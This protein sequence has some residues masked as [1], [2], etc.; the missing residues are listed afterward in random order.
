MLKRSK[1]INII[2]SLIIG[3]IFAMILLLMSML[4]S[5]SFSIHKTKLVV[6]SDSNSKLYNGYALTD[7]GWDMEGELKAGHRAKAVFRGSRTE[8]GESENIMHLVITDEMGMDVTSDYDI[9]YQFGTL[10]VEPRRLLVVGESGGVT[11]G[12]LDSGSYQISPDCDQLLSGHNVQISFKNGIAD[13]TV[14]NVF[15]A[16]FTKNYFITLQL[17]GNTFFPQGSTT[18]QV[19]LF[20]I[21]SDITDTVYLKIN[22]YGD[23]LGQEKWAT[24]PVYDQLIADKYSASYLTSLLL[25][26]QKNNNPVAVQIESLCGYYAL[27][28]YMLDGD[29]QI[30][31]NDSVNRGDA[32]SVYSVNYYRYPDNL[33]NVSSVFADYER[34][35]R[36]FVYQNYLNLDETSLE[37]MR[38]LIKKQGFSASDPDIIQ[39]VAKFIQNAAVYNLDYPKSLETEPNV[40]IAFLENYKEGVCRHY[41]ISATLLFRALGIPARYCVGALAFTEAGEWTEVPS[42]QAHAGVEVYLDGIGW[43]YVEVT[44]G[45]VSE[46]G[47]GESGGGSGEGEGDPEEGEK[48][49]LTIA[50]VDTRYR[51]DG[52]LHTALNQVKGLEKLEANGFTYQ[53]KVSGQRTD[54]GKTE[55]VIESIRIFAPSGEEV[56]DQYK[57]EMKKGL[58]HVYYEM[59]QF[60]SGN[61]EKYYDGKPLETLPN[62]SY[63]NTQIQ[64]EGLTVKFSIY[65]ADGVG[66]H[67]NTF[68]VKLYRDNQDVTDQYW[69]N[70]LFGNLIIK[71]TSITFKA[72][73]AQKAYDGTELICHGYTITSGALAEGHYVGAILYSGS[74]TSIGRSDNKIVSIAIYDQNGNDVTKNYSVTLLAGKL[75]VTRQ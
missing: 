17:D 58:L 59:F 6:Y 5:G 39:K 42:G 19:S 12:T 75:R 56:T 16:D 35:Y 53:V 47:G 37:Y 41:S 13:V 45:G 60:Q 64:R 2:C 8:A 70:C 72:D 51:Y 71:P 69:V 1:W 30:Q 7:H 10:T 29:Y 61:S 74:Q 43:V 57:F 33:K 11:E 3:L 44:G 46:G 14:V 31:T 27:P 21:Y 55:T 52:K 65:G 20:K 62:I 50:P 49:S 73:D 34:E 4:L 23:Y 24:A 48:I 54:A 15:G 67:L 22:S 25:S 66:T 68:G 36:N 32:S 26:S 18:P 63:N 40:A 38:N 28:Y 9:E